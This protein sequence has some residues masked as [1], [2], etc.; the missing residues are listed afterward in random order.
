MQEYEIM[1]D[2]KNQEP[3]HDESLSN[4]P[5]GLTDVQ[6]GAQKGLLAPLGDPLGNAL[7]KGLSPI[8]TAVGGITNGGYTKSKEMDKAAEEPQS[9]GG[10]EQTGQNPLGL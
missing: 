3:T 2:N 10:K 6:L 4:L 1:S 8:G 7:N 9:I 5:A